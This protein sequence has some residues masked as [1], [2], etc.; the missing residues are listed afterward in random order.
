MLELLI[1]AERLDNVGEKT[2]SNDILKT[3]SN[4]II[5]QIPVEMSDNVITT[6]FT[7]PQPVKL[8]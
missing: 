3:L 4:Y 2:I 8:R 5:N 6:I 1:Q 7:P